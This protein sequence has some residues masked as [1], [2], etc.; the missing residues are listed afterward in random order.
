M[1][2]VNIAIERMTRGPALSGVVL[3]YGYAAL[4]VAGPWIFTILGIIGLSAAPCASA[5]GELAVFRSVVIHNSLFALVSTSPLAFLFGRYVSDRVHSGDAEA[6][7]FALVVS[8]NLFALAVA[9]IPAPFYLLVVSLPAAS[10][11]AAIQGSFLIGLSWLLI[12]FLGI[13]NGHRQAL[14]A[15]AANALLLAAAGQLLAD[16]S[17]G[18]LLAVFNAGFA[19]TD[20]LMLRAVIRR[21]G[22]HFRPDWRRLKA[23]L[24]RWEL[25]AAGLAYAVGIWADKVV[26]WHAAPAGGLLVAGVLRTAPSYD[27]AM[28]WAQMASI[29]VIAVAFVHVE[30]RL[31]TLFGRFY[32]RLGQDASLRELSGVMHDLRDCV[33]S[34]VGM[35]FTALAIVATTMILMSFAYMNELGLRPAYMGILRAALWAMAFHTSAM[36]C[37]VFL[38]YFDLRRRALFVTLLYAVLNPLLTLAMLP[39][40]QPYYGYGS[41]AAAAATF[42]VAFAVLLRELP[43][44]H[45]HAFITNNTSL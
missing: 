3:A 42:V 16:P 38:L 27:T 11:F 13:V 12:P 20:T 2:G 24:R 15:F 35:L 41:M 26:M 14:A 25:P 31:S 33:I 10:R 37:F 1:S 9:A 22:N 28:F 5:C 18:T 44:L 40:G 4:L 21:F 30:T 45:F 43:W 23:Q 19:V 32:G 34:S 7:F 29:P 39:L 17:A 8:L 36:F 6:V